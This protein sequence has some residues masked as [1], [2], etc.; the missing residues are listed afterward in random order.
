MAKNSVG[1]VKY[2]EI[3]NQLIGKIDSGEYRLNEI[4]PQ[5][6]KLMEEFKVSRITV[7]NA[8]SLLVNDGYLIR[9]A[10]RGTVVTSRES[11][12]AKL[13]KGMN[14]GIF[15]SSGN[16]YGIEPMVSSLI[17]GLRKWDA[18][19]CVFP[20]LTEIDQVKFISD[21]LEKNIVDGVFLG[22]FGKYNEKVISMMK[23]KNIPFLNISLLS[24]YEKLK[25]DYPRL[26]ID[27]VT[28][29][30]RLFKEYAAH[31]IRNV[32]ILGFR[33]DVQ[34]RRINILLG[35]CEV[36]NMFEFT[37]ILAG[38]G[39]H[40]FQI[41]QK[42]VYS[43]TNRSDTLILV[44]GDELIPYLDAALDS[45]PMQFTEKNNILVFHHGSNGCRA[46]SRYNSFER[47][48]DKFGIKAAEM[49]REIMELKGKGE[50]FYAPYHMSLDCFLVNDKR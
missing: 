23:G 29:L 30:R 43:A 44:S 35:L 36:E 19:L 39:D 33:N 31:G 5:E 27:E 42:A 49:M 12:S 37:R 18:N 24:Q 17:A 41:A 32:H 21:I 10:R 7:R 16:Y 4:I 38:E 14:F 9:T 13:R 28:P 50:D 34:I 40:Y 8:L 1:K 3:A 6:Y 2:R 26:T 48:Y 11:N 47:P 15:H 20:F 22:Y 45:M 25:V 46:L